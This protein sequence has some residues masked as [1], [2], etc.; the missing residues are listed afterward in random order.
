MS[1]LPLNQQENQPAGI[2]PVSGGVPVADTPP[3]TPSSGGSAGSEASGGGAKSSAGG[4]PTQFGSSASKLGDYLKANAPQVGQQAQSVAGKF[5]TQYGQLQQGIQNAANQFGQ[6]VQGGYAA[7]NPTAV[8][9]AIAN[10]TQFAMNPESI[11]AFQGQYNNQYTGPQ[12]FVGT[13][14]YGDI[15]GQ[16]QGA[17][18]QANLLGTQAGLQSYLQGRGKNPTPASSTLDALL[19]RGNPGAQKTIQDAA[20][21]F[22]GLTSQLGSATGSAN[23]S[24]SDAQKAAEESRAYARGQFDPYAQ[25]FG[26][27]IQTNAQQAQ[28]ALNVYNQNITNQRGPLNTLQN[29]LS[30]YQASSGQ[31]TPDF[32]SQYFAQ[33][34]VA[35]NI[36]NATI[37]TPEQYAQAAALSQ[38]SGNTWQSPLDQA[39]LNQA[40]TANK[41][42]TGVTPFNPQ[43]TAYDIAQAVK[44]LQSG[45]QGPNPQS[46]WNQLLGGLQQ[47]IP[48][49]VRNAQQGMY[50]FYTNEQLAGQ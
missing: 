15:Q 22:G 11:K 25:G 36:T 30:G 41:A 40:G 49:N 44:A 7:S 9:Q 18:Q 8:N 48:N 10:P 35:N 37:A 17:Q 12:N 3:D 4:T 31:T 33:Q 24:V 45:V 19:L 47:Y 50:N 2:A 27:Q 43:S 20:S 1:F 42:P 13:Q 46:P 29:L 26:N 32:L 34:P 16:V 14:G 21:Q 28:N 38:L 6:Q 5:N 39:M 23:K